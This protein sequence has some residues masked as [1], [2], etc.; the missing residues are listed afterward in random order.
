MKGLARRNTHVNYEIRTTNQSKI[1]AKV[2]VFEKK[3]SNSKVKGLRSLYQMKGLASRNKHVKYE[4]STTHQSK[5]Y[6]QG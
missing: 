3:R 1:M 6:D 5:S 2:K 4:S